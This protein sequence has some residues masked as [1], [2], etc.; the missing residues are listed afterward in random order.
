[1]L[2]TT[3]PENFS[4]F[5][6]RNL[7]ILFRRDIW[8]Q[9]EVQRLLC[10]PA[11][12]ASVTGSTP[13]PKKLVGANSKSLWA[14][15]S[16]QRLPKRSQGCPKAED[17]QERMMQVKGSGDVPMYIVFAQGGEKP[18]TG[19]G[20]AIDQKDGQGSSIDQKDGHQA[21]ASEVG[22]WFL[23]N[24]DNADD[25]EIGDIDSGIIQSPAACCHNG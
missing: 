21:H 18:V 1:M 10:V 12:I 24:F 15:E 11:G 16:S 13:A 25:I 14:I 3:I 7:S 20:F 8:K 4:A 6:T 19:Q 23:Q 17:F 22:L 2:Y 9:L 5:I